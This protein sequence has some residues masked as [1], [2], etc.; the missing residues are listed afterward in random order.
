[1][2]ESLLR[3]EDI[4]EL[5]SVYNPE[6]D[7]DLLRRAYV[8]SAMAHRGQVR[9]SG[10][11]YLVHPLEVARILAEMHLDEIAIATGL[12]HDLLEDTWVSEDELEEQFGEHI[13]GL[14]KALTKITTMEQ[15][16]AAREAAQA[17]NVRRMLLASIADVRVIL[18]KLA[19]RLHNMRTL[20]HL[21]ED[22]RRRIA[23]E[24]ME[25]YAPIAHR[26]GMGRIKAELEDLALA[27][28]HPEE[29]RALTEQLAQREELANS[30]IAEIRGAITRVLEENSINA[31]VRGRIKH[32]NSIW[33]KLRRQ[34]I[35]L[36]RVYDFL[37]FRL[38]VDTVPH[39]YAAL[40]L[41]HQLWRP[42]PGRIKDYIAM[43]K[44][45]AYQS[46]HTSVIGPEGQPF[47]VQIRTRDM[48]EIAER[49]IAAHWL[50]KEGREPSHDAERVSW[51]R[52]LVEGQQE[53]PRDF[54][55][56]LKLNLYP[57]EVYTFTPKGEVFAFA[58]G[59]TPIDFAYRVH[60]EVGHH[61]V[62]A[63]INGKLVPLRTTLQNGDIVEILTSANQVPSRDWLEIAVTGR[64]QN[65]IRAWLNR[66]EKEQ[67]VEAGRRLLE[68]E[69]RKL[70]IAFKSL[71]EDGKLAQ[72]ASDHGYGREEDLVAAIGFGRLALKDVLAPIAR[73]RAA[74][75]AAAPTPPAARQRGVAD[76]S[77]I[78]VRGQRDL[79]T[80]RAQCCNPLPGDEI[81][82]YITRGRGVAVHA[83]HCP[84]V[85]KLLF[86]SEREVEVEWGGVGGAY[87][88]PL[89]VGFEDRPGM[90]AALSQAANEEGANIRSCHLA[91]NE[92]KL[93]TAELVV[94][95]QGREHLDRVLVVLR[96]IPG[97]TSV[98]TAVAAPGRR[99]RL[100]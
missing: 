44:P 35:G 56:S 93:G 81:V 95:V 39:C 92:D 88:V 33:T 41:I 72:L 85:R 42:V 64:A 25:I 94:D 20:G 32:L 60:T 57:E 58:R 50:Y 26:L 71:R 14:V 5:V 54:L 36:D 4:L 82:G 2:T 1:M 65:K 23:A 79:L 69:C 46:L 40:G 15:S 51:L 90:L 11:P 27:Y 59:A 86:T 12:L 67:A 61:C 3:F 24:T 53:N 49:G 34:G 87:A 21:P 76:G 80:Y 99:L 70:G 52:S 73:T 74:Q 97:V 75:T 89:H 29:H 83:A 43:P 31:E 17:E 84:N 18:V 47:E 6:C 63:R 16:Y 9:V 62:G 8:Y 96:R 45:N 28:Q 100:L 22:R 7:E 98:E 13:T 66:G 68:R 37:A 30:M 55:N 38:V 10:E 19:D 78:M 48:D 91:T 77:V